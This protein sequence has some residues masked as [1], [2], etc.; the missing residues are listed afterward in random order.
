[1]ITILSVIACVHGPNAMCAE[2][3][4]PTPVMFACHDPGYYEKYLSENY[5]RFEYK[6]YICTPGCRRMNCG[7][8][9]G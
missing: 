8:S 3:T 7:V 5:P 6:S 9:V 1:M 2:I 4:V